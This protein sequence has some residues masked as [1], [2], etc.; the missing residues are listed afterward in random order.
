[1]FLNET[2]KLT[3]VILIRKNKTCTAIAKQ[4]SGSN[5]KDVRGLKNRI[6]SKTAVVKIP[7]HL[8]TDKQIREIIEIM[9]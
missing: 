3:A 7:L 5:E 9:A 8:L 4:L 2:E 1:M 6:D